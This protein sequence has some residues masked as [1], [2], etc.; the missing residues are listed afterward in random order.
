[1]EPA[2]IMLQADTALYEA[3]RA[4]KG[5]FRWHSNP[6]LFVDQRRGVERRSTDGTQSAAAVGLPEGEIQPASVTE[7]A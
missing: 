3:K 7:A 2:T 1:M 5:R 6:T 4:G